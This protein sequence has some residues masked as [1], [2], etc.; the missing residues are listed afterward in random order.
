MYEIPVSCFSLFRKDDHIL[1]S[2]TPQPKMAFTDDCAVC[3][4]WCYQ[5]VASDMN[6]IA[7][8]LFTSPESFSALKILL[9]FTCLIP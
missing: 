9:S 3:G 4:D 5:D 6:K 2:F 7:S 8:R 1:N